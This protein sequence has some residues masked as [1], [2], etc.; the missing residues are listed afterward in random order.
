MKYKH[1]RERS[2]VC[3]RYEEGGNH[4]GAAQWN[5]IPKHYSEVTLITFKEI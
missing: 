1:G 5:W 4:V 3:S 2:K